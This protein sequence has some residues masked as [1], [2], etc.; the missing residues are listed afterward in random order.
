MP[1][2]HHE[3]ACSCARQRTCGLRRCAITEMPDAQKFGSSLRLET[4]RTEFGAEFAVHCRTWHADLF[5]EPSR[6]TTSGR[7]RRACRMVGAVQGVRAKRWWR[8]DKAMPAHRLPAVEGQADVV[9]QL[10]NHDRARTLRSSITDMS[11]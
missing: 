11:I 4:S 2:R 9:A 5:E 6:I 3:S 8:S 1:C 10:S 7:R